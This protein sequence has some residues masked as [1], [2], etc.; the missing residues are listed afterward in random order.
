MKNKQHLSYNIH[1]HLHTQY[2][3]TVTSF[4]MSTADR[5]SISGTDFCKAQKLHE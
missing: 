4:S 5:N 2:K 3:K 1:L